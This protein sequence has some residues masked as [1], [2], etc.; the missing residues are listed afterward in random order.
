MIFNDASAFAA[1]YTLKLLSPAVVLF[2]LL[3]IANT[4]LESI[5]KAKLQMLSMLI[6]IGVKIIASRILLADP[7]FGILGAPIGTVLSYAASVLFSFSC[8]ALHGISVFAVL[9]KQLL[10]ALCALSSAFFALLLYKSKFLFA[11]QGSIRTCAVFS[12]YGI[13]YFL[14]LFIT[15]VLN[16][17]KISNMSK[18]PIFSN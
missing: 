8:L 11:L 13:F 12:L 5:G 3:L 6:G 17:E 9:K 7:R 10:P 14:F 2:A 4:A 1:S 18:Q 16:V 15:G